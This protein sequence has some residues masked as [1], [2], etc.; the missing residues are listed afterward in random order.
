MICNNLTNIFSVSAGLFAA[1]LLISFNPEHI[2]CGNIPALS[3]DHGKQCPHHRLPTF[4]YKF[5]W[6]IFC[7][8]PHIWAKQVP[9]APPSRHGPPVLLHQY[10]WS[11]DSVLYPF[12]YGLVWIKSTNSLLTHFCKVGFYQSW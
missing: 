5:S 9:R 1:T 10:I 4:P 12:C 2:D 6:S 11:W 3:F 7:F 8:Q